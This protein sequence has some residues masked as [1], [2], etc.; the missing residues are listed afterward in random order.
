MS[1]K[2][3][4]QSGKV[5][6]L[7]RRARHPRRG[8]WT[9]ATD[10]LD[11]RVAD[12]ERRL[13]LFD[14]RLA[15]FDRRYSR[16]PIGPVLALALICSIFAHAFLLF[17]VGFTMPDPKSLRDRAP[18]LDIVLVNA[19]SQSKPA[20]ADVL[21]QHNLAGG[22]NT[23]AKARA[24]SPLPALTRNTDTTE[25]RLAQKR[26]AQ[27]EQEAQRLLSRKGTA[28]VVQSRRQTGP[29][30]ESTPEKGPVVDSADLIQRSFATA[31]LEAQVSKEWNAYQERPRR[32][33]IGAR[34]QEYR[35]ARYVDDWRQKIE[36]I[37][38][39]NYPQAARDSGVYGSLVATVSI[40]ANGTLERIQIDRSSGNRLL[41]DAAR[42]IVT[43]AAP[44][45]AFPS[46]IARDTDILHI[47][48][49][50]TFTRS[51]Q[52]VGQ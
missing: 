26:V 24:K 22:G 42:R 10:K 8:A 13:N 51:D 17:G 28:E 3:V 20:K 30:T 44:F 5:V 9:S 1:A 11:A 31:R 46:D 14:R 52:F 34:A 32:K 35:F 12:L 23:D 21:A 19:K 7:N 15:E 49:T 27:L 41:D 39:L 40:R 33:F 25:L 18:S 29:V 45:A 38:E 47:T 36:R 16:F 2:P 43:L 6:T 4:E 37:G 50:W 48:R